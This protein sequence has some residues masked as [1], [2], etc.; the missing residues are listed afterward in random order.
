L[1]YQAKLCRTLLVVFVVK[2]HWLQS[3]QSFAALVHRFDVR[4]K[5]TR[6]SR[7]LSAEPAGAVDIHRLDH[8]ALAHVINTGDKDAVLCSLRANAD[9]GALARYSG[10]ADIDIVAAGGQVL[11]G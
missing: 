6:G 3:Q 7:R 10:M 2:R 11:T 1:S 9:F 4:F 5:P 8:S